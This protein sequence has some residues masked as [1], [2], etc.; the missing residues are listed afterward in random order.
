M[1]IMMMLMMMFQVADPESESYWRNRAD[2]AFK[3]CVAIYLVILNSLSRIFDKD[4]DGFVSKKEF[5]WMT[6]NKRINMRKDPVD[7]GGVVELIREDGVLR[8]ADLLKQPRVGVKTGGIEDRV[9]ASVELGNLVLQLFV[10][11]LGAANKSG[12]STL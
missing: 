4:G 1:M 8:A 5:K 10:N 9:F 2:L 7:D 12:I 6:A 11:V 3:Y